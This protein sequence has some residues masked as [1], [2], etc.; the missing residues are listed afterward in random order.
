MILV[1][2]KYHTDIDKSGELFAAHKAYLG[3]LVD[4]RAVLASGPRD[5]GSVILVY[6]EDQQQ[7]RGLM[8]ADPFHAAGVVSFEYTSFHVGLVDP[9]S[10]LAEG[11]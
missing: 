7:A 8:E 1:L 10:G 2:G 11:C 9:A 6:G 5:G 4:R 3:S